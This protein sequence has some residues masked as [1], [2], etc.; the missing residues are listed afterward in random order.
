MG[1]TITERVI[2]ARVM[3]NTINNMENL[4]VKF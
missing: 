3:E 1:D 2:R 4:L